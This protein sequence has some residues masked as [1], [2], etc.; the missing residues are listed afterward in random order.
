MTVAYC[1]LASTL[2][3]VVTSFEPTVVTTVMMATAMPAAIRP[4]SMA[5]A[6]DSSFTKRV[7]MFFMG[8]LLWNCLRPQ[9]SQRDQWKIGARGLSIWLTSGSYRQTVPVLQVA[10]AI[11]GISAARSEP[12]QHFAHC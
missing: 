6:P 8:W 1:R 11:V 9:R 2:P 7:M 10:D 4:Y 3:K 5:V 12:F